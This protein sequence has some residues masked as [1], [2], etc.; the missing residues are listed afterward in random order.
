MSEEELDILRKSHKEFLDVYLMLASLSPD[1]VYGRL[2]YLDRV[3][4]AATEEQLEA[5]I[6]LHRKSDAILLVYDTGESI[7]DPVGYLKAGGQL[8]RSR[9]IFNFESPGYLLDAVILNCI[10]H[11]DLAEDEVPDVDPGLFAEYVRDALALRLERTSPPDRDLQSIISILPSQYV[12]PNT[13]LAE[14]ITQDKLDA[15]EFAM[16]VREPKRKTDTPLVTKAIFTFGGDGDNKATITGRQKYT[17]YDRA[18]YSGIISLYEADNTLFTPAM[19]YRAMNGLSE[20]EYVNPGTLEKVAK[21]IEKSRK[22]M[23]TIDYTDEASQYISNLEERGE[24]FKTTYEGNLL[25]ADKITVKNNGVEQTAYR[26]LRKPILYEYAQTV[27]QVISVPIRLLQT[28]G[29]VRSTE[30]VIVLREYLLRKI[31]NYKRRR[32]S[33]SFSISYFDIYDLFGVSP[34]THKNIKDKC[35]KIRSHTE[36]I[37]G[38]WVRQEY[39]LRFESRRDGSRAISTV[40]IEI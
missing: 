39:I 10:K 9:V 38:E 22:S 11:F 12:M 33:G 2:F 8:A 30:E 23:L 5:L 4:E 27:N 19:V 6:A 25:A 32:H 7:A 37:L 31:E 13:A 28:K 34:E 24:D 16:V 15:G 29:G 36:A 40:E 26:I 14:A 35:K 20:S 1:R 18:V 3:L 21:S 17:P